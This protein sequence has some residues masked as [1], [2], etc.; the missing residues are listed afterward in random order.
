MADLTLNLEDSLKLANNDSKAGDIRAIGALSAGS[1][2]IHQ[3]KG[4]RSDKD[5]LVLLE[6]LLFDIQDAIDDV[7]MGG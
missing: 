1:I 4:K 2:L 3:L 6:A 5:V 7:W